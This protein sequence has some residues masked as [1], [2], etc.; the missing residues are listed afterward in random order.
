MC[1]WFKKD[2]EVLIVGCGNSSLGH[3]M[4]AD[5]WMN[6]TSMDC[7]STVIEQMKTIDHPL[8]SQSTAGGLK[9]KWDVEDI[10]AMK[11]ST[12]QFDVVL[13]KATMDAL[14]AASSSQGAAWDNN[15][16]PDVHAAF[17]EIARVIKPG[18]LLIWVSFGVSKKSLLLDKGPWG[19]QWRLLKTLQIGESG[20][21]SFDCYILQKHT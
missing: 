20:C 8:A 19:K 2:A 13:D 21:I 7:S 5:G 3:D 1:E 4:A 18:G 12:G 6:I 17:M 10:R 14:L 15:V 11:Y 9:M 16:T